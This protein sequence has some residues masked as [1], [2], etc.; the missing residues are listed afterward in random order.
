MYIKVH[1]QR[2]VG[3]FIH[4]ALHDTWDDGRRRVPRED[5]LWAWRCVTEFAED[6]C[7]NPHGFS[8]VVPGSCL[9]PVG[10]SCREKG[11]I[12]LNKKLSHGKSSPEVEWESNELPIVGSVQASKWYLD[13]LICGLVPSKRMSVSVRTW[14]ASM[15]L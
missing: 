13:S 15:G 2:K 3:L 14:G 6:H 10:R 1:A 12:Q 8:C 9:E 11:Q 7:D 5:G 4:W